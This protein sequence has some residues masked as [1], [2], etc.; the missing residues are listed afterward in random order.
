MGQTANYCIVVAQLYTQGECHGIHPFMVQ[1]RDEDTH[2]PLPGI[3][4]GDIGSKAGLNSVNNGFL[5]LDNVRI[6]RTNMLMKHAQVLEVN[7]KHHF[8]GPMARLPSRF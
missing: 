7:E 8:S 4:I 2:M 6:P 1:V 5:G 3:K